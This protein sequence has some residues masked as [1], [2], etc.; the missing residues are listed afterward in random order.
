MARTL[1]SRKDAK[2]P[3]NTENAN[4]EI[5]EPGGA[6]APKAASRGGVRRIHEGG[7]QLF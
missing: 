3:R 6:L 2:A 7:R 5:G 4:P 1:V